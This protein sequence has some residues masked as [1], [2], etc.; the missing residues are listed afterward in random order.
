M[1]ITSDLQI[2][3]IMYWF[4]DCLRN[5]GTYTVLNQG[6]LPMWD[7]RPRDL[8]WLW[9]KKGVLGKCTVTK[10]TTDLTE[11]RVFCEGK[12][13]RQRSVPFCLRLHTTLLQK[14]YC[15]FTN[16]ANA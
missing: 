7:D 2:K 8:M 13:Q 14:L 4:S 6:C 9:T 10:V 11:A 16:L 1:D 12:Y 5:L 15:L 3:L